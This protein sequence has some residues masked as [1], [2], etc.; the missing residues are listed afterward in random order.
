LGNK[1]VFNNFGLL[2]ATSFNIFSLSLFTT[3]GNLR[4][5]L[6]SGLSAGVTYKRHLMIFDKSYEKC[7]GIL[8]Q[9]PLITF[10]YRPSI[11]LA[12]KGG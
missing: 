9:C 8:P 10:L 2:S 4:I 6:Q 11:S 12:W 7:V 5:L 1:I 3:A